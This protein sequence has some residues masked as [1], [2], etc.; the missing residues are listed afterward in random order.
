VS[1]DGPLAEDPAGLL[2][3]RRLSHPVESFGYRL[4]EPDGVR[5]LPGRLAAAGVSGPDVGRLQREGALRVGERT[6]RLAD[7]SAPRP[8]QRF[9]FVMDTR[10]CDG[11]P[12]LADGAD[13]LVVESTFLHGDRALAE[14]YGHLTA[15]QAA[16]VAGEAGVRTLVLTHFSQR[17]PDARAFEDEAG[18]EFGGDLVVAADLQ[19]V[20]VPP[21]VDAP[22]GDRG[23]DG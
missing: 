8:G 12:A 17:Y 14:R 9:A 7:V 23:R 21:R 5:M 1:A 18:A 16:R 10:M 4:T 13:L 20:P 6:V 15:R 22:A 2:E 3:A 19:R 11:V